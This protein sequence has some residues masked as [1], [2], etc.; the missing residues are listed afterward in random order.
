MSVIYGIFASEGESPLSSTLSAWGDAMSPHAPDGTFVRVQGRVGMGFQA[1]YTHKRSYLEIQPATDRFGNMLTLD[2][3]IDNHLALA[4]ELDVT[5]RD[6]GDSQIVLDGFARWGEGCFARLHGDWAL[7]LWSAAN[8]TL[9]LA[10]DHAGTRTLYF[11]KRDNGIL[12]STYLDT[13]FAENRTYRLSVDFAKAYLSGRPTN[14][15][16]PYEDIEVVPAA[17]YIRIARSRLCCISHWN[18]LPK[19]TLRYSSDEQYEEQFRSLFGQAVQRRVEDRIHPVI[20]QLSGGMDSSSIVCM[21]DQVTPLGSIETLSYYDD[22][23]PN[24]NERPYFTVVEQQRKHTGLHVETPFADR[25]FEPVPDDLGVARWPG[26]TGSVAK[27]TAS[28]DK[29][30]QQGD[31][32]SIVSGLG[33]DELLGGVPSP[34]PELADYLVS[35]HWSRL[36]SQG[37]QWGLVSRVPL[38]SLLRGALVFAIRAYDGRGYQGQGV[39]PWML[40]SRRN[41]TSVRSQKSSFWE[42]IQCSPSA[43][44]NGFMWN[45]LLETLPSN[46]A[47]PGTRYEYLFPYLDKDLVDFLLRVP[48]ERLLQPGRRRYLMRRAL[49]GI[50]PNEILERR[51]K[52]YAIRGPLRALQQASDSLERLMQRSHLAEMGVIDVAEFTR[53]LRAVARGATTQSWPSLTQTALYEVWLQELDGDCLCRNAGAPLVRSG[54]I[55]SSLVPSRD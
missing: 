45:N 3:R 16:T 26:A 30:L 23:E 1:R 46:R 21:A 53:C 27:Q 51:R 48:P 50:V 43:V 11:C 4:E 19:E 9:Y 24:W 10:R 28:I 15:L 2:G 6:T 55:F 40:P 20:A 41:T 8:Q 54:G 47:F 49:R 44:A 37:T 5:D 33:G 22:A 39:P 18:P 42:R 34:S 38:H 25:D 17:H 12:W 52:A 7:A 13:F 32:R 35:G 14:N 31:Y 29:L 36:L